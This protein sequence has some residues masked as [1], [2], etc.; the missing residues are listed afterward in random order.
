[1]SRHARRSDD[2]FRLVPWLV[3]IAVVAALVALVAWVVLSIE[4]FIETTVFVG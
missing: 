4:R 2:R 1:M 3:F